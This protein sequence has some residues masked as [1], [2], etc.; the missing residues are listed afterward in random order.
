MSACK[1]KKRVD[2][3]LNL[4]RRAIDPACEKGEAM[5]AF[6]KLLVIV[7]REQITFND[8]AFSTVV[9]EQSSG[10]SVAPPATETRM[11][12]G[13]H[14]GKTLAAITKEDPG[15]LYWVRENCENMREN[16]SD[17]IDATIKWFSGRDD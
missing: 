4:L 11:P 13:K 15:Y 14:K 12:F 17:A 3:A 10:Q 9:I 7:R 6:D 2:L 8:L 1:T 16:L 5:N